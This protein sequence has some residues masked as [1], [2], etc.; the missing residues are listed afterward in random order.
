M[1]I[2]TRCRED[3]A[4]DGFHRSAK[5]SDGHA[6]WCKLCANY[7]SRRHNGVLGTEMAVRRLMPVEAERLQGFPD[8]W[9]DVPVG[10]RNAADGPRYKQLGNSWAVPCVQW[11]G[12]RIDA[13]IAELDA[14]QPTNRTALETWLLAA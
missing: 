3:K 14:R 4:L 1:K 11:I 7:G 2:C 8:G 6:S 9:T 10:N 12:R 5:A 13:H